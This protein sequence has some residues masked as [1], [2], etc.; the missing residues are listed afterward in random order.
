MYVCMYASDELGHAIF[1]TR[2]IYLHVCINP[3]DF[4]YLGRC[5][6]TTSLRKLGSSY[7]N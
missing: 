4:T 7:I 5:R 6:Y 3:K 1:G 2:C